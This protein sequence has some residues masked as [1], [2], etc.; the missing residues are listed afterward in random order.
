MDCQLLPSRCFFNKSST[1]VHLMPGYL[2]LSNC[3]I[4]ERS[5]IMLCMYC[6][7][8]QAGYNSFLPGE[9]VLTSLI[10]K[11]NN[12]FQPGLTILNFSDVRLLTIV[13]ISLGLI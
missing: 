9:R 5:S 7:P 8:C 10:I 3:T 13:L 6:M 12:D 11:P 2:S 4:L 1:L